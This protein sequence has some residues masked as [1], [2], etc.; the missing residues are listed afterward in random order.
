MITIESMTDST[1]EDVR[2]S[3]NSTE[4]EESLESPRRTRT[5][6]LLGAGA[7]LALAGSLVAADLVSNETDTTQLQFDGSIDALTLHVSN[8]SVRVEGSDESDVTIGTE[9]HGGLRKPR[10]SEAVVD[11]TL[12]V[13]SDCPWGPMSVTCSIDYTIRVPHDVA[14]TARGDGTSYTLV[15]MSG[16]V[17]VSL[18]GGD[19]DLGY[20][21]A[22]DHLRALT[23]GGDITIRVPDDAASYNVE[24]DTDGGSVHTGIR[25][26]PVSDRLIDAHADGGSIRLVYL[27]PHD[28]R[29]GDEP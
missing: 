29:P 15:A 22:P 6:V 4:P 1:H 3:E 11:D 20:S 9:M 8:G 21:A 17:D 14:V 23:N 27:D 5:W 26:D 10:H 16:D 18:N 24:A 19:A 12:V 13:R 7:V 2:S 28:P 25:T